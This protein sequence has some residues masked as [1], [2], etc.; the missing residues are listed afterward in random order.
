MSWLQND[1]PVAVISSQFSEHN[2]QGK[3]QQE[4]TASE[5]PHSLPSFR[6][7]PWLLA[8]VSYCL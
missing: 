2:E 3:G 6:S 8:P 5:S 4:H 7:F 1:F